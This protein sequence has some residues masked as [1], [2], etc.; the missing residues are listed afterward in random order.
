MQITAA[1][2][3]QFT[4]R[5]AEAHGA[6]CATCQQIFDVTSCPFW[7]WSKSVAM[8]REATGHKVEMY[9]VVAA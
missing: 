4:S 3:T 8:H 5:M 9:K 1:I 7:H 6:F 2:R